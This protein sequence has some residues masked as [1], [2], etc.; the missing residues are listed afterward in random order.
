MEVLQSLKGDGIT[1]RGYRVQI[2]TEC[3]L[4]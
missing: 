2:S 4:S 3:K 1:T